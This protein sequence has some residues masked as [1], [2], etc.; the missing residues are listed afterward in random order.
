MQGYQSADGTDQKLLVVNTCSI[1]QHVT[2]LDDGSHRLG[3]YSVVDQASGEGWYRNETV[4]SDGV[5]TL[6][7]F[8]V[9]VVRVL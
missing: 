4:G 8:A 7:P 3:R 5:L 6:A 9:A 1:P 2:L